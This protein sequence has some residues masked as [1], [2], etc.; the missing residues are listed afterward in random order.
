MKELVLEW[1]ICLCAAALLMMVHELAKSIVYMAIQRIKGNKR[2]Y[3]HSIWAVHR[4]LDPVGLLLSVTSGVAFS[5]PFM[6]RIQEKRTNR[7]L[8]VTGFLVL[9]SCFVLSVLALRFQIL[10]VSGM[11]TLQGHGFAAKL[12]TL[13]VQ[14]VAIVSFGMLAANLFPISTFDMGL[15]I[16]GISA[17]K[18]LGI[19][20]MDAV[21]KM[22]FIVTVILG[23]IHYG[24]YRFLMVL[25]G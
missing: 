11:E 18:Y 17:Q 8:G 1:F 20:K 16:A 4:Y 12:V 22:I 10:G 24:G 3:T 13:F 23:L 6:F 7:I 9:L 5:K 2:Q 14:Y 21:I 15:L 19:I 25:V